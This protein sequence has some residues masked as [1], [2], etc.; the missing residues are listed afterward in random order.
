LR[1]VI[2]HGCG[3]AARHLREK[4]RTDASGRE[5]RGSV[6]LQVR[7]ARDRIDANDQSGKKMR[8]R[9]ANPPERKFSNPKKKKPNGEKERIERRE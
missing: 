1:G 4:A 2:V 5:F 8:G 7:G 3:R 9:A 6:R